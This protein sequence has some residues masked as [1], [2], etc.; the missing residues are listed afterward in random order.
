MVSPTGMEIMSGAVSRSQDSESTFHSQSG[1]IFDQEP[2]MAI[3]DCSKQVDSKG[4]WTRT[5]VATVSL[6]ICPFWFFAQLT[7]NLSLK[8]T[9]VTATHL[10]TT[11]VA[12]AGLTIQVPIAAVV[13]T[14]TGHAP[15]L[16]DY[17][18]AV[19]VMIGFAGI[20][21]PSDDSPGAQAIPKEVTSIAV[22]D[23]HLELASDG[24]TI[25]AR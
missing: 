1:I 14:L 16:M 6:L 17:I 13:D 19:A 20:N 18:G 11:T 10:T 3:D 22:D 25:D 12:T 7:F 15:H 8:Y 2:I 9:T 24:G 21:I 5:R 23:G 4:R